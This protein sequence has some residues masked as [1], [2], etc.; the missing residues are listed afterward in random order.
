MGPCGLGPAPLRRLGDTGPTLAQ[1]RDFDW[2]DRFVP[3]DGSVTLR[4]GSAHDSALMVMGP[5][6]RALLSRL[7]NADLSAAA[8][9]WMSA[10][11][12]EVAGR[13]VTALRVSYVGELGWELH[14][15]SSDLSAVYGAI[16]EAGGDLGLVEFGSLA[17]NAMRLE[18][19]WH[20]WGADI[21]TEY[22]LFDA[23]LDRFVQCD[24]P[25]FVGR[26]AVRRQRE[27]E[28]TWRFTGFVIGGGDAD[29]LS[30]D[31]ILRNGK[32]V[33][34]G[35]REARAS[36]SPNVWP[37]ATWCV[38]TASRNGGTRSRFSGS[39]GARLYRR[40]H[41]TI[42]RTYACEGW[43]PDS[44]ICTATGTRMAFGSQHEISASRHEW[45]DMTDRPLNVV[46]MVA[47]HQAYAHHWPIVRS[48]GLKQWRAREG[49]NFTRAR[50]VLP[51][52]SPARASMLTGLYPHAHGVTENDGR[53]GDRAGLDPGDRFRLVHQP[54]REAGYRCAW[55]GKWHV[56]NRRSAADYGFEGFSL[57]GYGYP[58][59]TPEYRRYLDDAG[60]PP[61]V[62]VIEMSGESGLTVGTQVDLAKADEWFDYESGVTRLDGAA[63]LNEAFFLSRLVE[64]WIDSIGTDPFFVRVDPW[65]PHPPYLLAA[66][67]RGMF[68]RSAVELS[69]N[70][71]FDLEG[72]PPHHHRYRD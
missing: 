67:W 11:Q 21:G 49:C 17:L 72:R 34:Y 13:R 39:G 65:G 48:T 45:S 68:E 5:E 37:W 41:S 22:S 38:S 1:R 20:A 35:T 60:L 55:F 47:D 16:R 43:L 63:K 66:P 62:A 2:L 56:D 28:S 30:G 27:S 69:P 14:L 18:K 59:A 24:K 29:P 44:A 51:V 10:A 70:F 57:P 3:H 19:G 31:P 54:L 12:F 58:Y 36:G 33:G 71:R 53:F 7:T 8:A 46:W 15:A 26:D 9:P 6:S 52:C 42:R 50:T 61:P 23:G 25:D 4:M 64:D 40:C 32:C